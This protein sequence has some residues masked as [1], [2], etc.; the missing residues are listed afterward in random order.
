MKTTKLAF[1]FNAVQ[2]GQKSATVNAEPT[3]TV[4][5]TLGKMTITAPVSKAMQIAVGDNVM[6]LNNIAKIEE[7]I[8]L[9]VPAVVEWATENGIDIDSI[10]GQRAIVEAN[11][12]WGIAKGVPM[13]NAKGEPIMVNVRYS[14]AEKE[15][16]IKE[17]GMELVA[18]NREALCERVGNPN[19]TDEELFA[20]ITVDDIEVPTYHFKT[21]SKTAGYGTATGIGC[22]LNFTD[23]AVW[24]SL[25]ANLG[26]EEGKRSKNRIFKVCL[27]E[28]T[29]EEFN[30]GKEN[31]KIQVFPL[32]FEKDVDPIVRNA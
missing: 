10:E 18:A 2:A 30:N 12:V 17:H 22:Q 25:K 26:D 31:V 28:M 9:R 4:S 13:Y 1:G 24:N 19:A 15:D 21:G 14:K 23:T 3:L 7:A 29:V 11:T 16:F 27:E 8:A 32:E 6:F 5:T 20:A